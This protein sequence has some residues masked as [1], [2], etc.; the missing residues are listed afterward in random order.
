MARTSGETL[1]TSRGR[2]CS[3]ARYISPSNSSR[4]GQKSFSKASRLENI[5]KSPDP[6]DAVQPSNEGLTTGDGNHRG[7]LKERA[8]SDS[9]AHQAARA[10]PVLVPDRST[11]SSRARPPQ[12]F[13]AMKIESPKSVR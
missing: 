9:A 13:A 6:E 2:P 12:P 10:R 7:S 11:R 3:L 5:C 1:S 8:E 4:T